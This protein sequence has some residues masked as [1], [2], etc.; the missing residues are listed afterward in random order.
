MR[1][2]FDLAGQ[3]AGSAAL[4]GPIV[5]NGRVASPDRSPSSR[6]AI[7]CKPS[8]LSLNISRREMTALP[9][10]PRVNSMNS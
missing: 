3:P 8:A 5:E 10:S 6:D 9:R 1:R 7:Y 2:A 4:S